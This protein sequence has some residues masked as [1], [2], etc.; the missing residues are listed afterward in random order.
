M[1]LQ[2]PQSKMIYKYEPTPKQGG[3]D[4]S[5]S[6]LPIGKQLLAVCNNVGT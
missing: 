3:V 6:T 5:N 2:S 1:Y 4:D